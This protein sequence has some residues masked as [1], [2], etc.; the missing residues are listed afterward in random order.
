MTSSTQTRLRVFVKTITTS[1]GITNPHFYY[2]GFKALE[3][4]ENA[5]IVTTRHLVDKSPLFRLSL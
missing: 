3:L 4:E 5:L 2:Y 1:T